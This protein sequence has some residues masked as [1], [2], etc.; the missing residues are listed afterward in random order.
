M[1]VLGIS[2]TCI[3]AKIYHNPC[4]ITYA[5]LIGCSKIFTHT[6]VQ[7]CSRTSKGSSESGT[8]SLQGTQKLI[9]LIQRD[10]YLVHDSFFIKE[11]CPRLVCK[12]YVTVSIIGNC[13]C[14]LMIASIFHT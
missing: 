1:E 7:V 3:T 6:S 12:K 14:T 9:N 2:C 11:V 8:N 5:R 10:F 4:K 13:T